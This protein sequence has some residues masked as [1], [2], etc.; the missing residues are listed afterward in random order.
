MNQLEQ[1]KKNVDKWIENPQRP[2][3]F[4]AKDL[5]ISRSTVDDVLNRYFKQLSVSRNPG[6]GRKQ[7]A[8]NPNLDKK[9]IATISKNRSMSAR[10][11]RKKCQT[12]HTMVQRTKQRAGMKTYKKQKIPKVTDIHRK[13]IKTRARK[14]YDLIGKKNICLVLDDETY[15]K[16]DFS[17]LPG[18][19]YYT[20]FE[21]EILP[22][23]ET[24]IGIEKFGTK[25]LVWQAICQCGMKSSSFVTTGTVNAE[26]YAKE[27]L[28]KRMFPFLRKHI[29]PT[30]F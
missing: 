2:R 16:A 26:T 10:N 1:R 20:Q 11:I 3:H 24:S 5:K 15:V 19:Q 7:G 27:C 22:D 17:T 30:L 18:A 8:L 23:S 14:L 13:T 9:I 4:I 21:R 29:G 6:S 25:Y 28:K 12:N